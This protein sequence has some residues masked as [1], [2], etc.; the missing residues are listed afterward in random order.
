MRTLCALASFQDTALLNQTLDF[1]LTKD[2]RSQDVAQPV[3]TLASNPHGRRLVRNWIRDK[4][5]EIRSRYSGGFVLH[6]SK[7]LKSLASIADE[8]ACDEI[9][10]LLKKNPIPATARAT[11]QLLE[12]LKINQKFRKQQKV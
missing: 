4:Y 10:E 12:E 9:V 6:F 11:A 2:V 8:H 7:M 1:L 5:H 3:T